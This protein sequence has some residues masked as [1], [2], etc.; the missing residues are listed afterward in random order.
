MATIPPPIILQRSSDH[1]PRD[2]PPSTDVYYSIPEDGGR[3]LREDGQ[4]VSSRASERDSE[5]GSESSH[6][7]G[8]GGEVREERAIWVE[9]E[10]GELS[11]EGEKGEEEEGERKEVDRVGLEQAV[12]GKVTDVV[13]AV[14]ELSN[15]VSLSP[16]DQYL[17][18]VKVSY[19]VVDTDL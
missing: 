14:M 1:A 16:P 10:G 3:S 2:A 18:L 6:E 11:G 4:F 19:R 15:R 17:E 8:E 7:G 12:L 5:L 9:G 13:K